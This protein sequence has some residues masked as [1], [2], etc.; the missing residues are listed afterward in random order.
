[1]QA[2]TW[3]F[4]WAVI[5]L[6]QNGKS[7]WLKKKSLGLLPLQVGKIPG[8]QNFCCLLLVLQ[9]AQYLRISEKC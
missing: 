3:G 4:C 1:M 6:I 8:S 7:S 9:L 5:T 2:E